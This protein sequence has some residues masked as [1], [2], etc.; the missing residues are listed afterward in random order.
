MSTLTAPPLAGETLAD[1]LDRLGGVPPWRVLL[2]PLP[3]TATETDVLKALEAPRKRICELVDG[4]LVEKPGGKKEAQLAMLIGQALLN[5]LDKKD[6]GIVVGADGPFR[7]KRKLVRF[8]DVAFVSWE[9]IPEGE[10]SHE[11]IAAEAPDL[12]VEVRSKGNTKKELERKVQE[13]FRAGVRLVW[14]IDPRSQTA[15]VYTSALKK[16]RIQ[17]DG[18]LAGEEVLPG[19]SL[20]LQ[21]LFR[22]ANRGRPQR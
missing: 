22:R 3:G 7:L 13:Y 9:R 17:K 21:E 5:F 8:P 16:K 4:V 11:P 10:F 14:I 19:F 20:S 6:L 1:L 2:H 15:E 12:A 18:T